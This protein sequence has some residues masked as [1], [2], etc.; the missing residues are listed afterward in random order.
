M[1]LVQMP[2]ELRAVV[3]YL[4]HDSLFRVMLVLLLKERYPYVFQKHDLAAGVGLVLACEN[5]HE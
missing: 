3:H 4:V 5:P 1:L 2:G